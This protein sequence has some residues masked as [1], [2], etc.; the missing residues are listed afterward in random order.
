MSTSGAVAAAL[1]ACEEEAVDP[2]LA[3]VRRKFS[4]LLV[5]MGTVLRQSKAIAT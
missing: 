5:N 3:F 1:S 2:A 4:S